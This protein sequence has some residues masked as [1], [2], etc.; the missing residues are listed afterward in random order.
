MSNKPQD[1]YPQERRREILEQL[2]KK[3]RLSVQALSQHFNVSEVTI[4]TDLQELADQGL[5]IRTHGGAVPSARLPNL[6]FNIR[7]NHQTQE[8][9]DIGKEAA[10]LVKNSEAI[11]LDTSSTA[12]AIAQHLTSH[13]DLTVITNSLAIAEELI[14]ASKINLI[15]IGGILQRDTLSLVGNINLTLLDRYNIQKGFFGAAGISDPEGLTD[16][17]I[18]I[19]EAKSNVMKR[20][21]QVVAVLDHTKWDKSG[22]ATFANLEDIHLIITDQA[23]HTPL[24]DSIQKKNIDILTI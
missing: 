5:L 17:N 23:Y 15:L 3:G 13:L 2:N 20:C 16:I 12:L 18:Y 1:L 4:R 10:N 7:K 11:Y 24:H 9:Q 6:S 19:A 8:K 22:L 14:P 21:R